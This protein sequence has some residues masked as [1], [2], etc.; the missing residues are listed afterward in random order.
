[1]ANPTGPKRLPTKARAARGAP[2]RPV[3]AR[4]RRVKIGVIG[5]GVAIL[6]AVIVLAVTAGGSAGAGVTDPARFDLPAFEGT[7]RVQLAQ[8][9]GQPV[10]VNLFASWCTVCEA[11]LPAFVRVQQSLQGKVAFVDVNSVETGNGKAMAQRHGLAAAGFS[12]A[13]DIGGANNSGYHDALGANGMPATAFYDADGKLVHVELAGLTEAALRQ[14]IH[15]LFG[16]A[17]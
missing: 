14:K 6:V 3:A 7:G 16:I 10:V 13:H 2:S 11:E 4:S 1:M 9:H 5:G 12:L 17:V 8:F 15:E